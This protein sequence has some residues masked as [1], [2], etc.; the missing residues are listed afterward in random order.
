M[1]P[2][3]IKQAVH[4]TVGRHNF[5]VISALWNIHRG[6]EP[7]YQKFLNMMPPG[8]HVL[9]IG[10]NIG[11]TVATAKKRRPDIKITAFEPI[12]LHMVTAMRVCRIMNIGD[13]AF[14]EVALGNAD[15][16]AEM[17]TPTISGLPSAAETHIASPSETEGTRFS[18][19]L[20]TIDSFDLPK[21]HG[22][23]IDVEDFEYSVLTGA[24]E[25]LK[26]DHPVIYSELHEGSNRQA[27][28][29]L[30][31]G[32]GYQQVQQLDGISFL[33]NV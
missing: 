25:L 31:S 27:V 11:M 4:K 9:D 1:V 3:L 15:G 2:N 30:L 18:V 16:T 5:L 8:A 28:I 7:N 21:V 14:H 32:A 20:R 12:P 29:N 6:Y 19:E 10:A 33:F 26:R 23:K 24:T 22:I 13:V 17:V